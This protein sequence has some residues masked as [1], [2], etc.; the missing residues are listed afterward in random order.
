M[1]RT[2]VGDSGERILVEFG[3]RGGLRQVSLSA[4]EAMAR[5]AEAVDQA[6]DTIHG[7]AE[8]VRDTVEKLAVRPDGVQVE[9]GIKFDAEAG[10]VIAKAG[11]E[12][13]VTVTLTWG[14]SGTP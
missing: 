4:P 13:A 11:V 10:A 9:F 2:P 5:S 1:T 3:Q 14:P 12:A 6:M 7:M 8:R